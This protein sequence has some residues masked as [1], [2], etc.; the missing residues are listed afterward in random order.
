METHIPSTYLPIYLPIYQPT[1]LL[2]YLFIYLPIY[3]SIY[4]C[5]GRDFVP[6]ESLLSSELV[7][8][9][10]KLAD[11]L[12]CEIVLRLMPSSKHFIS[13]PLN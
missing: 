13:Q 4:L 10:S 7:I 8:L 9:R 3:L 6:A 5:E 1:Y 11:I 2:I 12:R